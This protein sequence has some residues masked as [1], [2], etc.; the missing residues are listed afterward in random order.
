MWHYYIYYR[1]DPQ[2]EAKA[3]EA[4]QTVLR[5]VAAAMK[6][7]GILRKKCDEPNLWMEVYEG[8]ADRVPFETALQE[9]EQESGILQILNAGERRHREC[10][11]D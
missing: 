4:A 7:Q 9:A 2:Q 8:I 3:T 5:H 1:V 6:I 11:T 10:F